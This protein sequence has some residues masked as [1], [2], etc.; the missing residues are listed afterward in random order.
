MN[1]YYKTSQCEVHALHV[2]DEEHF[3]GTVL[4]STVW[5]ASEHTF[6]GAGLTSSEGHELGL[7]EQSFDSP[8]PFVI[9]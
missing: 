9:V 1:K 5:V 3:V 2:Q 8:S 7:L 6:E 4:G